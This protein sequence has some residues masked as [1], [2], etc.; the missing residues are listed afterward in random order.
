MSSFQNE[1]MRKNN[2]QN[3]FPGIFVNAVREETYIPCIWNVEIVLNIFVHNYPEV[4]F[5]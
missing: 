4:K 1:Y 2:G 5:I 3:Y